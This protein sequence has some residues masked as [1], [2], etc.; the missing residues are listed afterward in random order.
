MQREK[1]KQRAESFCHFFCHSV[2][3]R[4]E[5]NKLALFL[6]IF[7]LVV[8]RSQGSKNQRNYAEIVLCWHSCP[9]PLHQVGGQ[10]GLWGNTITTFL[11]GF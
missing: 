3:M 1:E 8:S 2:S 7:L 4:E 10:I 6:V 9:A 5:I 11:S